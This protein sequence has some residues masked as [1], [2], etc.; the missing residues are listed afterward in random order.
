MKNPVA[1]FLIT[2]LFGCGNEQKP[3][4][5]EIEGFAQ[6]TTY[7]IVYYDTRESIRK[8]EIDSLLKAFDQSCSLYDTTSLISR[9]N[10]NETDTVDR[11][12]T[13]CERI[14]REIYE[15]SGGAYDITCQPLIRA[16]GFLRENK[17]DSINLD[18]I[19][20]LIGHSK[21]KI[22]NGRLIKADP[23]IAIDLNSIAQGYS[24]DLVSEYISNRGLKNFLVEI[25][26]EIY[27]SG[28]K[29]DTALWKVGI[30]KP[31]DGN[32][33]AGSDLQTTLTLRD[34]GLNT[35]GNYRKFYAEKGHRVNHIIDPRTGNSDSNDMLSATVIA[36]TTVLADGL[37]TMLMV[38]G[39][40][41][42]KEFLLSRKDVEGYIIYHHNDTIQTFSTLK[43]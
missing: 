3:S 22:E 6:G 20:P 11:Y 33:T 16:Y 29:N 8:T 35:S 23:R 2:L 43:Q 42:C 19:L 18:S 13:E 41:K 4:R 1:I 24:V 34:K 12:I 9:L 31:I 37:A 39:S 26:G 30:D 32:M 27:C 14:A 38:I 15:T 7:K 21:I 28:Q 25:G 10:R 40:D 17:A 5:Y 36:P